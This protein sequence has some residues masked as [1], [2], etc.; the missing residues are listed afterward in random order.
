MCDRDRLKFK[1][2]TTPIP[3]ASPTG[4]P[5]PPLEPTGQELPLETSEL[6]PPDAIEVDS[7]LETTV[8]ERREPPTQPQS[9]SS[10]ALREK[11]VKVL[12]IP[13]ALV[14]C[15]SLSSRVTIFCRRRVLCGNV[16]TARWLY[17]E[18][19]KS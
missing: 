1:M 4:P 18:K 10:K 2:S 13:L 6:P 16:S 9:L 19:K 17:L 3:S 8:A 14:F 15:V 7:G 12:M 11:Q 5:I